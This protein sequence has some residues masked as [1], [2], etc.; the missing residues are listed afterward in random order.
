MVSNLSFF[1][2]GGGGGPGL[3]SGGK[4]GG[5]EEGGGGGRGGCGGLGGARLALRAR[6]GSNPA[7]RAM[8]ESTLVG[9]QGV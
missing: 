3:S 2:W 7:L 8:P 5:V 4:G 6:R 1:S 9:V